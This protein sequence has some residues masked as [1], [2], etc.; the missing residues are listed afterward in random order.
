MSDSKTTADASA[1]TNSVALKTESLAIP[2]AL[3]SNSQH[4]T[5]IDLNAVECGCVDV[6]VRRKSLDIIHV[7]EVKDTSQ[8]TR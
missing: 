6:M 5:K 8:P 4:A 2:D 7:S 1:T 3:M